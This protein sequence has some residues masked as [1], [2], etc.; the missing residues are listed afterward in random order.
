M[1]Q[2][3]KHNP[4]NPGATIIDSQITKMSQKDSSSIINAGKGLSL[5]AKFYELREKQNRKLKLQTVG[6]NLLFLL[7]ALTLKRKYGNKASFTM[8]LLALIWNY[9]FKFRHNGTFLTEPGFNI[10]KGYI[11]CLSVFAFFFVLFFFVSFFFFFA[12]FR[13]I[14][15]NLSKKKKRKNP[16]ILYTQ[17]QTKHSKQTQQTNTH[18]LKSKCKLYLRP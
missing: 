15:S 12:R 4:A 8:A 10:W 5:G 9:F 3:Y 13:T 11:V 14:M 18:K 6:T 16:K 1:Q 17:I 7:L 2:N